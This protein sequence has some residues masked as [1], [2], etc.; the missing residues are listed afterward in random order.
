MLLTGVGKPGQLG[1]ALL[2]AFAERGDTVYA[3]GRALPDVEA[4]V[5]DVRRRGGNAYAFAADLAQEHAVGKLMADVG[6]LTDGRLDVLM[7]AAG[8]FESF[9]PVADGSLGAWERTFANN[10]TSA[11]LVTRGSLPMLRV[12]QGTIVYIASVVGL[13]SAPSAG[14]SDYAAAK[15]ALIRLMHAVADEEQGIVRANAIAP[16]GIKT[17]A[18]LSVVGDTP[19]FVTP[20]E[21]AAKAIYLAGPESGAMT[22]EVVPM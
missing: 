7:N 20:E 3:T 12:A 21:I 6:V 1:E 19:G 9:G 8:K 11:F 15:A 22:G 4:L 18:W 14:M 5:A 10:L 2:R 17:A 13:P 16:A